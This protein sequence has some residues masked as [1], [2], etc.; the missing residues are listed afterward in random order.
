[1]AG[2]SKTTGAVLV[3][4]G[5][6]AGIQC[7]LDLAEGGYKVHLVEKAPALG[8]H[9]AQLDKT[10]PTNDCSMC[11]LSPKLVEVGRH[12]NVELITNSELAE[13]TGEP[14]DF[15]ATILHHARYVDPDKCTSCGECVPVCPVKVVDSFNEEQGERKAIY[16]LYPQAI[17][18]TYAVTKK[19]QSPCK[20]ACAV[21]T[22]AQG[23]V[24]LIREE[25]FAEAYTVASEPNPFPAVCG[26][27]C[28][29]KCET[30]CTRGEVD[31]PIAIAGLKRF[32]SDYASEN[33]PLPEP[34]EVRH[35]EQVAIV[36]AG[37]AGLSC[38]RDLAL[39][40]YKTTVFEAKSEPGGMLRFGIPEYRLPKYALQQDIDRILALGVELKLDQQIGTELTVDSLL[41]DGYKAVYLATGLQGG[42]L[43]PVP[44]N[45]AKGV[46]T[47]V[48]LLYDATVGNP[49]DMGKNVVVIGGG[50]VAFDAGRTALRL[51][52]EKVTIT[53]IEDDETMPASSDEIEE[54]LG[55]SITFICSC[56][57]TSISTDADGRAS[58]VDFQ[59]CTLG[60]ADERGW[61]PPVPIDNS[62]TELECDTVIFATGQAMIADFAKGARNVKVEKS[63]IV[64][65]KETGATGRK[66]VFAGGD[67]AAIG[68]W[69]AIEAIAAGRRGARAIHNH[70]R[71][72]ELL[73]VWEERKPEAK[74]DEELLRKTEV[75]AR[76]PMPQLPGAA[77]KLT[78][79]EVNT[80]FSR[81]GAVAEAA[82]CLDCAICS[83]CMEC[84]RACGPGALLHDEVDA[85]LEREIGAVIMATG[86]DAYD[87]GRNGEHGYGRYPN[88]LS[89][90]EYERMLSASGPTIGDVKRPSDGEHPERIAFIQCVGSRDQ[91][92]DYCSSV[93][94]MYATKQAMLT[95]DHL[96]GADC[97]VLLMDMRAMGKGFDAF[98][99][100][101]L[102]RGVKYVRSRPSSIKEDPL[103]KNL[104][105]TLEDESGRMVTKEYDLVVLSA[106]LEPA[107]KA[108]EVAGE[109]GIALNRHGFCQL[110]EYKPLETSREGVYVAG[111]FSEPKDIP[112]SVAQASAAAAI[113]MTRLADSRG[114]RTSEKQYPAEKDV[115]G[116]DARVGVF[117]CHCGSNI[118]GV[119]DVESV[120]DY[121]LTLPGVVY[122][123]DTLYTC[124]SDSLTLIRETIEKENLNRVV[125]AS[126]TPRTHEPI[127]QDTLQEAGLNPFLFEMSNIRDQCSWV[128]AQWPHEATAKAKDLIR[129]SVARA[130]LLDPLYKM[131][132]PL[133]HAALVIG[134]GVAGMTAALA[135]G[136]MGYE[137]H[138]VERTAQLGGHVLQIDRT[139]R[140]SDPKVFLKELEQRLIDNPNV[141]IHLEAEL[142]DFHGFIGNF[143]S[144]VRESDGKRTP[145]DHGVVMV[146][147]GAQ[148]QRPELYGLGSSQKVVTQM[149]LERRL[150]ENDPALTEAKSVGMILCAG[151]LDENKP[152]C[153]RTCCLQ[154]IKNAIRLKEQDP[155]RPVYV[156]YKD[157]RTFGLSEEYYTRA[158]EL[159]VIFTRYANGG[160]PSVDANGSLQVSFD[161]PA[162]RKRIEMPLDLLVLAT[163]TIPN[164]GNDTLSQML[165]VPLTADGFFLEAHVKLRPV[166]F[167][168]EGIFL[169]GSAHYP[170]SI[171]ESISQAYAAAARA[172]AVLAK[173]TLKAGGVVAEVD[174]EKCAACLTCVRVCPY[175]VPVIDL[176][177]KKARIEA[178]ACQGCGVCVAE[179]PAKAITLHHYTDE[180][181][182][183]KEEALRAES[184]HNIAAIQAGEV[185]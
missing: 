71:G 50:D 153:S 118:A 106:G 93:C 36:G 85:E 120:A 54:G 89:S 92:H 173:A 70:L 184:P 14:G 26:R 139:V 74:P 116:Q 112:D 159:G 62:F 23:Y 108:Q 16:K 41:K 24:A 114:T 48:D 111:P 28:T 46:F 51:G 178:A 146:A 79:D 49:V 157:V 29:H 42:K 11:T 82:R 122:A 63:Q 169:C 9:M 125:V 129:M 142:V 170:K 57:P 100:R 25:R 128:H 7:A 3:L 179:C 87:P 52:A 21:A 45:D 58:K 103:S 2:A 135:L 78:W 182:F 131:D 148:E 27:I 90:L 8:G 126:C 181:V 43:L 4:G 107:R 145:I 10:F 163:P 154:A 102:D 127:F 40:G 113:A 130:R 138:L 13:L 86:Y 171:D 180:Q 64:A 38:A 185:R 167:A 150:A 72:K 56:M 183:A 175:E 140:G 73:P 68:P 67:A 132:V 105:I 94:C 174:T 117:V 156:W 158:R 80:G 162:L 66:G 83:E 6:V 121:A 69:T 76:M 99:Q 95:Q 97:D 84:V 168:S 109:L 176:E 31:E 98:Y 60:E 124:S 12:L 96:P 55:E 136:E 77:R 166:D 143:S 39:L 17:P 37:P 18:N 141:R 47:A 123:T 161:E 152:Y 160:E 30:D 22:S 81:E 61:R 34:A 137:V 91:Q 115:K 101:A 172:A 35:K 134:G 149:D 144:V 155:D 75:M 151:S 164:E 44:G 88:V 15:N 5:G 104:S 19:G 32:V 119:V 1:M 65:D 133:T 165:K 177:T 59:Y 110:D 20:R 53:C 33:V 147:T